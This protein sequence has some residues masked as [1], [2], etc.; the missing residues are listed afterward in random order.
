LAGLLRRLPYGEATKKKAYRRY[1]YNAKTRGL[2]FLLS[3]D[4][5]YRLSQQPCYYCGELNTNVELS[6][7]ENGDFLYNGIDRVN[8]SGGYVIDNCVSCCI[9][10]NVIKKG[11]STEMAR[12]IINFID[13]K[14]IK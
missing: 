9:K 4:E 7:F 13:K 6:E 1:V 8:N 11:I 10:C 12:K 3:F 2:E 5:F 14:G